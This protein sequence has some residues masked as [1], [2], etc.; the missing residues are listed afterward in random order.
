MKKKFSLIL[1]FAMLAGLLGACSGNVSKLDSTRT[2]NVTGNGKVYLVPDIAYVYIG[3]HSEAADVATAL[4]E[5]NKQ[6]AAISSELQG[7]GIDPLDIQ[8]TAFNVYPQQNYGPD[9]QQTDIKYVVE[10][11]VFVKVKQLPILGELLDAVVR[12][13]ANQI[14]G[15]SFDVQDRNQA[16]SDARNLAIQDA[17]EKATEIA[18]AAGVTLGDLMNINVYSSGNPQPIFDAKGGGAMNSTSSAP[19]ASGQ[20][21]I[22]ADANLTYTIK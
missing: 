9:G 16:E 21:L 20:L 15:I 2:I 6:A 17:K 13:G 11:T 14:N 5:N 4:N 1:M 12:K 8:T 18:A 10:N 3:T 22:T 7:M 19:I